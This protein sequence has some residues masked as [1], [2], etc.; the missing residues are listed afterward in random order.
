VVLTPDAPD[1]NVA[2]SGGVLAIALSDELD[3]GAALRPNM[4]H[5]SLVP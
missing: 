5:G 2:S 1:A 3:V 4:P